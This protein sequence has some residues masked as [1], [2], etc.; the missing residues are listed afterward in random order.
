MKIQRTP[1]IDRFFQRCM[2]NMR[3]ENKNRF[4]DAKVTTKNEKYLQREMSKAGFQEFEGPTDQWPS[5]FIR[6]KD[7]LLSPYNSCIRLDIIESDEFRFSSELLPAN[8]LFNV[9]GVIF[10]KNRELN[11]WMQLRALD[12]PYKAAVLWQKDEVWML[13]APSE[14]NTIDPYAQ[15]AHGNVL[16]FGLGIGYFAFMA[17]LNPKVTSV[18]VI[19]KSPSVIAMFKQYILPQFPHKEKIRIIEGDAFDYFNEKSIQT[20]NYVFVDIWKSGADGFLMIEQMLEQYLPPYDK[21]DFWIESSCF[22]FVPSIILLYFR[23]IINQKIERLLDPLYHRILL[24]ISKYFEKE[25]I[26]ISDVAALK[27][28]MY[29]LSKLREI[30]SIRLNH[31]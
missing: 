6:S 24:K 18:T 13:D 23:S 1:E 19:E 12:Q 21:V 14:S 17:L 8:K 31:Y 4:L 7:F 22:E 25:D 15:K 30:C 10:D 27:D 29:D 20:F 3:N 2:N 26:I 9:S 28:R 5:L 16:T 11:D